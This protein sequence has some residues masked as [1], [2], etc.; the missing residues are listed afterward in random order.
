MPI[1]CSIT[2]AFKIKKKDKKMSIGLCHILNC[3][4]LKYMTLIL[5]LE[6]YVNHC[7]ADFDTIVQAEK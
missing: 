6:M 5:S 3:M 2:I 4:F 1:Y 7:F